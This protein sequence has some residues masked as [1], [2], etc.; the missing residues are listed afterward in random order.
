M[1]I[2]L[3]LPV[4]L[5]ISLQAVI[6][7]FLYSDILWPEVMAILEKKMLSL[8]LLFISSNIFVSGYLVVLKAKLVYN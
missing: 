8:I 7:V 1:L 5:V 4:I 2:E 6:Y 3:I